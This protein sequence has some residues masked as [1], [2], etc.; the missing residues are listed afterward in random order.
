MYQIKKV[1]SL[2]YEKKIDMDRF[3][4]ELLCP[5]S[6]PEVFGDMVACDRCR[7]WYHNRCCEFAYNVNTPWFCSA[8]QSKRPSKVPTKFQ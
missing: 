1:L 2:Q 3:E 6:L 8:C 4:L 7:K 5:C